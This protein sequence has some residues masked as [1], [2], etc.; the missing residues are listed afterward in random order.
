MVTLSELYVS[1]SGQAIISL[2]NQHIYFAPVLESINSCCVIEQ[3]IL[4][5]VRE[6]ESLLLAMFVLTNGSLVGVLTR[7]GMAWCTP[8]DELHPS[9]LR[10]IAETFPNVER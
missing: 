10:I 3:D 8:P 6:R 9:F 1:G 7:I 2:A 4:C 5:F